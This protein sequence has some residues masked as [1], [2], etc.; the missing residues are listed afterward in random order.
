MGLTP[1]PATKTNA[2]LVAECPVNLECTL[3]DIIQA[4]DHDLF[5]GEA[6]VQHVDE[7][8]LDE[9]GNI[10][11]ERLN[12]LCYILGQYWSTGRYLGQHGFTRNRDA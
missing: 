11:I 5:R 6:V 3:I 7:D 1:F 9:D 2:P 12:P 4:G 10:A 8:C